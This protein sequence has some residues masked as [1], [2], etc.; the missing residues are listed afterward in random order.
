MPG[1]RRVQRLVAGAW[2]VQTADGP[3][4]Y[5]DGTPVLYPTKAEAMKDCKLADMRAVRVTVRYPL[6]RARR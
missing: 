3:F 1:R 5:S 4:S 6:P 2:G